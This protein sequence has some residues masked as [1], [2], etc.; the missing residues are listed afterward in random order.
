VSKVIKDFEEFSNYTKIEQ[1]QLK[2][3]ISEIDKFQN[4]KELANYYPGKINLSK[5]DTVPNY[6]SYLIYIVVFIAVGGAIFCCC[7]TCSPFQK[8]FECCI[9]GIFKGCKIFIC[10]CFSACKAT[11]AEPPLPLASPNPDNQQVHEYGPSPRRIMPNIQPS[12]PEFIA[13][14]PI[15]NSVNY[16]DYRV[17]TPQMLGRHLPPLPTITQLTQEFD[18]L[19]HESFPEYADWSIEVTDFRAV[20][21]FEIDNKT[22]YYNYEIDS[23]VDQNDK[24]VSVRGPPQSFK[25]KYLNRI[26]TLPIPPLIDKE[27]KKVIYQNEKVFYDNEQKVYKIAPNIITYGYRKPML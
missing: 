22:F 2:E 12:I 16:E 20:L 17:S 3:V 18:S 6:I 23:M 1:I 21:K 4:I 24:V 14:N 15:D 27:D 11:T 25:N 19:T 10:S 9:I 8:C 5:L 26:S 7:L 13:M